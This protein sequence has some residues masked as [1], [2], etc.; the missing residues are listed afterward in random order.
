MII[1]NFHVVGVAI[2]PAKADAPLAVDSNAVLAFAAAFER[3]EPVARSNPQV[4]EPDCRVE[5]AQFRQSRF[6][7]SAWELAGKLAIPNLFFFAVAKASR[8][9]LRSIRARIYSSNE[10]ITA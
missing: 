9:R 10:Y 4:L 7:N 3:F 1:N 5:D 2:C 6:L 8:S